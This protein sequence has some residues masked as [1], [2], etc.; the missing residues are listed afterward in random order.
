[1]LKVWKIFS[2]HILTEN[3]VIEWYKSQSQNGDKKSFSI[4]R[5]IQLILNWIN[6]VDEGK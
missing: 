4:D 2:D 3:A 5:K 1:M 6:N